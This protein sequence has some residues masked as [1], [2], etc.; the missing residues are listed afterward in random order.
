M[1][2]IEEQA[3]TTRVSGPKQ[4]ATEYEHLNANLPVER[5]FLSLGERQEPRIY[6]ANHQLP[7]QVFNV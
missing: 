6:H 2:Y 5:S 3:A 4:L 1:G 7:F